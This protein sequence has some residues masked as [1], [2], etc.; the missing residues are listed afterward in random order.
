[1][2]P[3]ACKEIE[4]Y[5]IAL[6]DPLRRPLL[7]LRTLIFDTAKATPGTGAIDET[8][9]WNVPAYLTVEPKSGTTIRIS[10]DQK[11]NQYGLYV[12]CQTSLIEQFRRLY[13]DKFSFQ[14][15]RAI[16]FNR[17]DQIAEDEL[18]HCIAMALTYHL[19]V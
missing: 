19:K 14:K 15:N 12:H 11:K 18:R 4:N 16:I 10:A 5:F 6:P 7:H 8:L 1:M 13:P 3:Y 2:Q 9:K 17:D